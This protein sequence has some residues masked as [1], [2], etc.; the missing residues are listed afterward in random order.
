M[1]FRT[2]RMIRRGLRRGESGQAFTELAVSLVA[3]LA[4]LVGFLL[5]AAAGSDRVSA[6]IQARKDADERARDNRVDLFTSESDAQNIVSA[7][8][9]GIGTFENSSAFLNE[10]RSNNGNVNLANPPVSW[11]S[12]FSSLQ[13]TGLFVHAASLVTG[14]DGANLDKTLRDHNI[15]DLRP[16][17]GW[18]F[19]IDDLTI[20]ERVYMP[21]HKPSERGD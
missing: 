17:I 10:L 20:D 8:D 13:D 1:N 5:I 6:L 2:V 18:L 11:K 14:E 12:E 4:A 15:G 9:D 16:A 7:A 19:H 21:V 3:I